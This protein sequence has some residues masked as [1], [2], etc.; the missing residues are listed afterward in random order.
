MCHII[1]IA[2]SSNTDM[3]K[4]ILFGYG[5][6]SQTSDKKNENDTVKLPAWIFLSTYVQSVCHQEVMK[7]H[8][9]VSSNDHPGHVSPS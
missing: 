9:L 6:R 4:C 2:T 8:P 5:L 3:V 7:Q 1:A